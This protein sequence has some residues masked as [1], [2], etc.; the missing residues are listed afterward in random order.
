MNISDS[1]YVNSLQKNRISS[2]CAIRPKSC[3][4]LVA[5]SGEVSESDFILDYAFSP[6]RWHFLPQWPCCNGSLAS[7]TQTI[8]FRSIKTSKL[9]QYRNWSVGHSWTNHMC[10][11]ILKYCH[12]GPISSLRAT[13][14][15]HVYTS[16]ILSDADCMRCFCIRSRLLQHDWSN[17]LMV[18]YG[19]E[20]LVA[21]FHV[22]VCK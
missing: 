17:M 16:F 13:T 6:H 11:Q 14:F 1:N 5:Q 8:Q 22:C 15:T 2:S 3:A 4:I 19:D 18:I 21:C 12:L 7:S 9:Q 10:C 20:E